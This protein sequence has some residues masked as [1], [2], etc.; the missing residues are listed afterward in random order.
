MGKRHV[1]DVLP[2]ILQ[3]VIGQD[4]GR[5]RG[6]KRLWHGLAADPLL[7]NRKRVGAALVRV[8]GKDFAVDHRACWQEIGKRGKVGEAVGDQLFPPA[9]QGKGTGAGNKLAADAVPFP[10]RQPIVRGAKRLWP[11]LKLAGQR[12]GVRPHI[13]PT[14][15]VTRNQCG[16]SGARGVPVA[17]KAVGEGGLF[18]PGCLRQCPGQKALRHPHAKAAGQK[19]VVKKAFCRR[20]RVPCG[21]HCGAAHFGRL[22]GQADQAADGIV[23]RPVN[24]SCGWRQQKRNSFRKIAD[25]GIAFLEQPVRDARRFGGPKAQFG[26]V[27]RTFRAPSG[28]KGDGPDP[29]RVGRC[30]EIVGK[31]CGLGPGLG[32]AIKGGKE[33][34]KAFHGVPPFRLWSPVLWEDISGASSAASTAA[35]RTTS[36]SPSP[37]SPLNRVST[38]PAS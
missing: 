36:A 9:P 15:A 37:S 17:H 16:K 30:A 2:G 24:M 5:G 12:K 31:G 33:G 23:K 11:I 4:P 29:V 22:S 6:E 38:I 34:G 25:D 27:D 19:F 3:K 13:A 28:Q 18:H 35:S 1:A 32:G 21:Q 14:S 7:Q 20:K 8:P 10:F 26:G